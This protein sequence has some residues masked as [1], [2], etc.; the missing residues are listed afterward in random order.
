MYK[1]KLCLGIS[2]QFGI[3]EKEQ[4]R[5]FKETGFDAYFWEWKRA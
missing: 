4:I 2:G 3:S 5:L 1:T